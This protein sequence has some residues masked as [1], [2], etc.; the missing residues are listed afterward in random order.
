[1]EEDAEIFGSS[2]P[3]VAQF[4]QRLDHGALWTFGMKGTF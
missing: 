4:R 2:T 1:M 3:P